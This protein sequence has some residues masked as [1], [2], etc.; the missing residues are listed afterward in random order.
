MVTVK[1]LKKRYNIEISE[2]PD[3][4]FKKQL[5]DGSY[6]HFGQ[7]GAR[8]KLGGKKQESYCARAREIKTTKD[9]PNYW[10]LKMWNCNK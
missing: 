2:R 10:S 4:K 3:K 7:Q 5:D 8:I 9:S 1:E 6:V